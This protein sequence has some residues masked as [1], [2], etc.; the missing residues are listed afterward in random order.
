MEP[1]RSA[2]ATHG[3]EKTSDLPE[4]KSHDPAADI[5]S[6]ATTR[7]MEQR[8][9]VARI[10]NQ[11]FHYTRRVVDE[12]ARAHGVTAAQIGVLI[13]IAERPGLSGAELARDMLTTPQAAQL[14][15]AT[16][17]RKGLIE[18]KLDPIHGRIVRS[19]LT[20]EGRRVVEVSRP[21]LLRIQRQLV[22]V[23]NAEER[24]A[25]VSLLQRYMHQSPSVR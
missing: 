25:F 7:T 5:G 21:D 18:R 24:D 16:L 9:N 4:H 17:E 22:A 3:D 13:R 14:L 20:D 10:I 11:A 1:P 23:F 2:A 8:P 19:D 6:T 12:A 15:L